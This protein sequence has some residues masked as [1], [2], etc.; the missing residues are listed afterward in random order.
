MT[1][2]E[3]MAREKAEVL[4]P[5]TA[6]YASRAEWSIDRETTFR[7]LLPILSEAYTLGKNDGQ[8]DMKGKADEVLEP[9]AKVATYYNAF[10]DA[11]QVFPDE[12]SLADCPHGARMTGLS[13]GHCRRAA[14]FVKGETK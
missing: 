12:K 7:R 3:K 13:L 4:C 10:S 6:Y 11:A 8:R 14:E 9:F 2:L 5:F 1:D